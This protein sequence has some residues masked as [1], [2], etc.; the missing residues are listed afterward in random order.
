VKPLV[1]RGALSLGREALKSGAQILADIAAKQPEINIKDILS[2]R[3]AESTQRLVA[4]LK[5]GRESDVRLPLHLHTKLKRNGSAAKDQVGKNKKGAAKKGELKK[6]HILL[7]E[8][9]SV[10]RRCIALQRDPV[11]TCLP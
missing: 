8:Q 3:L 11:S 7:A 9:I 1:I 4:K 6:G 5:G 10:W 2:D